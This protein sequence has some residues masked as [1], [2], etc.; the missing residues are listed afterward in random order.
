MT[1]IHVLSDLHIDFGDF[2]LPDVDSDILV[3][4]GDTSEGMLGTIQA[5]NWAQNKPVVMVAGNHEFYKGVWPDHL[6]R[7]R[8]AAGFNQDLHV[9]ENESVVLNGTRFLGCTLWTDFKLFGPAMEIHSRMVARKNMNDYQFIKNADGSKF[10]PHLS[11]IA[12]QRSVAWLRYMLDT[13]FSG[14]TVVV[15]HHAPSQLM[16]NS[17]F[18]RDDPLNPAYA[19]HLEYL[20]DGNKVKL[21]I[22]GHT[23]HSTQ[24][25]INDTRLVSNCRGYVGDYDRPDPNFNPELVIDTD[26]L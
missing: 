18:R 11:Q 5:S 25:T 17:R 3:L 21:W 15:T 24:A 14:P 2:K 13:P 22:S 16:L 20:M 26:D 4:A 12:H 1:R 8:T 23:H 10:D 9:L 6:V 7:M 19:S